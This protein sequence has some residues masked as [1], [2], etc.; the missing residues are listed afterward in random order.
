MESKVIIERINKRIEEF[1]NKLDA[2]N[3]KNCS[4]IV[5]ADFT[6]IYDTIDFV[7]DHILLVNIIDKQLMAKLKELLAKANDVYLNYTNVIRQAATFLDNYY[8]DNIDDNAAVDYS[9]FVE[10]DEDTNVSNVKFEST[11]DDSYVNDIMK[12]VFIKLL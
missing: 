2:I 7:K 9:R 12:S 5:F 11:N 4:S 1:N 3:N 6:V 8:F 10:E